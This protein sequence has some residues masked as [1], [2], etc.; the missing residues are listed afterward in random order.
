[1][2]LYNQKRNLNDTPQEVGADVSQ[3]EKKGSLIRFSRRLLLK[4]VLQN[5]FSNAHY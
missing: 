2:I 1:M 3:K 4:Q 5:I